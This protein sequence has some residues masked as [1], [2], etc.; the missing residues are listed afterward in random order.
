MPTSP[1]EGF[2]DHIDRC[3]SRVAK[4]TLSHREEG[5]GMRTNVQ[6]L[7]GSDAEIDAWEDDGIRNDE[8]LRALRHRWASVEHLVAGPVHTFNVRIPR[9]RARDEARA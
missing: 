1:I 6:L 2:C 7:D 9:R 8:A 3:S 5:G 4:V